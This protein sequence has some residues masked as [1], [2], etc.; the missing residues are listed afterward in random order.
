MEKLTIGRM[1]RCR[2]GADERISAIFGCL[3]LCHDGSPRQA[4]ECA[5]RVR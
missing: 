2:C 1:A 5:E 4:V 3:C